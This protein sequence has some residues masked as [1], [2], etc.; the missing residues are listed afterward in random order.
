MRAVGE[1]DQAT[2]LG[3]WRE[4]RS[5]RLADL[6]CCV[7]VDD[8]WHTRLEHLAALVATKAGALSRVPLL[9]DD[10]RTTVFLIEQLAAANWSGPNARELWILI[11]DRLVELRDV[12]CLPKLRALAAKPPLFF[13]PKMTKWIASECARVADVLAGRKLPPDDART[14]RLCEAQTVIP[15]DD[16]F[17]E[18]ARTQ[19]IDTL[20]AEVWAAP[21]DIQ[22]RA[23]IGDALQELGDSRGVDRAA[24]GE[25]VRREGDPTAALQGRGAARRSA[26]L[27]TTP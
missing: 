21:H 17:F 1:I 22:L 26:R 18:V 19:D 2:V 15:P 11:F 3:R 5:S 14:V 24:A 4:T 12:R 7:P 16:G 13:Q 25:E 20:L 6:L 9:P 27:A 23:V 8:A 10:P